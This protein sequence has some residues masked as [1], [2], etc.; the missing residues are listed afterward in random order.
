[1]KDSKPI[2]IQTYIHSSPS[3]MVSP[4]LPALCLNAFSTTEMPGQKQISA[5]NVSAVVRGHWR[6][7]GQTDIE[8]ARA[9][10]HTHTHTRCASATSPTEERKYG[11]KRLVVNNSERS[12]D[13]V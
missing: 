4:I 9:R 2:T 8:D 1:L 11:G 5:R 3:K 12:K 13:D 6:A 7:Q 10:A